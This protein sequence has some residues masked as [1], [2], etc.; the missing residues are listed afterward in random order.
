MDRPAVLLLERD[1]AIIDVARACFLVENVELHVANS[2]DLAVRIASRRPLVV[3]VLDATMAG[4]VPGETVMKLKAFHHALRIVFLADPGVVVDRRHSQLGLVLRKPFTA[5]RFGDTVRSALRLQ[6]MSAGVQRMRHSSGTYAS[7]HMSEPAPGGLPSLGP[8]TPPGACC[9]SPRR[10]RRPR[11]SEGSAPASAPRG[12]S[13]RHPSGPSMCARRTPRR[14]GPAIGRRPSRARS[15]PS[16]RARP[17]PVRSSAPR[18]PSLP[19]R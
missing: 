1:A 19:G 2:V 8:S 10:A 12:R 3:A 14:G 18:T 5:E 7:V 13:R 16:P 9:P 6:S 4:A 15:R 17:R 11:G